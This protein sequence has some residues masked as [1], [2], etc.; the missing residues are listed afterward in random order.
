M[1]RRTFI[2]LIGPAAL[3]VAQPAIAQTRVDLPLVGVLLSIS[4]EYVN[5]RITALRKGLQQAGF[6]EGTNYTLAVRW[7]DGHFD[8]LPSLVKELGSL[9][10]RVI[11]A[12]RWSLPALPPRLSGLGWPRGRR[13]GANSTGHRG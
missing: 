8:R 3:R 13:A 1:R 6:S 12:S 5:E 4:R 11:V 7:A 10:P 9:K 2:G